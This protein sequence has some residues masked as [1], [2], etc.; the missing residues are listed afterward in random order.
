MTVI[1]AALT[2]RGPEA[3]DALVTSDGPVWVV[4]VFPN[5]QVVRFKAV[6]RALR[7]ATNY[8]EQNHVVAWM[9]KDDGTFTPIGG[10]TPGIKGAPQLGH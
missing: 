3:G 9:A 6:E 8:A 7:L 5:R 10:A 1:P 4:S 2:P